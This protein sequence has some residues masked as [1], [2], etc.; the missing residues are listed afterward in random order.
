MITQYRPAYYD[1]PRASTLSG[2]STDAKPTDVENGARYEEIDTGKTFCFDKENKAW[3]EMPQSGGSGSSVSVEPIT[4][5]KNGVTTAPDGVAYSPI[6]TDTYTQDGNKITITEDDG[7]MVVFTEGELQED[8]YV[9]VTEN[10]SFA[11]IPDPGYSGLKQASVSMHVPI[12]ALEEERNWA[13]SQNGTVTIEPNGGYDGMRKVVVT[14]NVQAQNPNVNYTLNW[15]EKTNVP[16]YVGEA[17]QSFSGGASNG[18][19]N[20]AKNTSEAIIVVAELSSGLVVPFVWWGD[21]ISSFFLQFSGTPSTVVYHSPAGDIQI[22]TLEGAGPTI[23]ITPAIL[24][25]LKEKA[26]AYIRKATGDSEAQVT[27]TSASYT[28]FGASYGG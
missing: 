9:E 5:T 23:E 22:P 11:I 24:T 16:S 4:I 26:S 12:P 1:N 27:F 18:L 17:L 21:L 13:I 6:T 3:Y 14:T 8:K 20:I 2:L 10:L 28:L 15:Q 7:S 19:E 25:D